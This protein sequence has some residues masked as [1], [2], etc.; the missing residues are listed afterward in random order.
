MYISLRT[1]PTT[2]VFHNFVCGALLLC[3]SYV[4]SKSDIKI[5]IIS[6]RYGENCSAPVPA[7]HFFFFLSRYVFRFLS[8]GTCSTAVRTWC[9]IVH[10]SK[11]K[12]RHVSD[13]YIY[14][15]GIYL[16]LIHI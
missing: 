9:N 1:A 4:A 13:T 15:P 5:K 2:A 3:S 8:I 6:T 10:F 7:R 14:I 11:P 16:S 12:V